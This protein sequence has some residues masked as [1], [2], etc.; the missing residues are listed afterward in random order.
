LQT[1]RNH[2]NFIACQ[3]EEEEEE[4]EKGARAGA[5]AVV[6]AVVAARP[7]RNASVIVRKGA[8]LAASVA[9]DKGG[10]RGGRPEG[11][12]PTKCD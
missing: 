7:G 4:E 11:I 9:S 12:N 3:G 5:A 10:E 6:V 1:F 8:S 2:N